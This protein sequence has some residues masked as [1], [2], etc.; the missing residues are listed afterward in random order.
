MTKTKDST[1]FENKLLD[2]IAEPDPLF[3]MMQWRLSI[4]FV[5]VVLLSLPVCFVGQ[6]SHFGRSALL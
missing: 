4:P 3:C 1:F 2:F 5:P 6:H